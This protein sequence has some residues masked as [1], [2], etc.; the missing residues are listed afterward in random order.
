MTPGDRIWNELRA[1]GAI[2]EDAERRLWETP[3]AAADFRK[4]IPLRAIAEKY[5]G[6]AYRHFFLNPFRLGR[7]LPKSAVNSFHRRAVAELI[8][9]LPEVLARSPEGTILEDVPAKTRGERI[10]QRR[11]ETR[12]GVK[13]TV[14]FRSAK[15]ALLSRS[16]RRLS[17][18]DR[19]PAR[20]GLARTRR[21]RR[22]APA[23][24]L[25]RRPRDRLIAN[26]VPGGWTQTV[27]TLTNSRIPASDNSRP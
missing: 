15:A 5:I 16:E 11:N 18:H 3:C 24:W 23:R 10:R 21:I 2:G 14:A 20:I 4:D 6:T 9:C 19:A 12:I 1:E 17:S 22:P 26:H 25:L 7:A 27:F 8:R 13:R